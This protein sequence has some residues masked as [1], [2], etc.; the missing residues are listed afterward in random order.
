MT[1]TFNSKN[2]YKN[3]MKLKYHIIALAAMT[4]G[5]G[6]CV[7]DL[8]TVP[9]DPDVTTSET[10][11]GT[12]ESY[13]QG[14]AKIYG[15]FVTQGQDGGNSTEVDGVDG[16][17]SVFSRGVWNCQ[18]LP[19]D[20]CVVAWKDDNCNAEM[21]FMTWTSIENANIKATYYR[22]LFTVT[23]ANEYLKQTSDSK[24]DARGTDSDLRADIAVYRAETRALRAL[25][26]SY[27]LDIF[28]NLPFVTEDDPIG[29]FFP[30]QAT[31]TELFEYIESELKEIE[32]LLPAP[33]SAAYGHLD[34]GLVWGLL[35]RL[36][37]NAEVYTGTA[38][39]S[40]A[41]TWSE[42]LISSGAYGLSPV[43][44][45]LF[46]GD[47]TQNADAFQEIIHYGQSD[48]N[49][50]QNYGGTTYMVC[51]S[52]AA[53]EDVNQPSGAGTDAWGG[54]R[55]Q[56]ALVEL[57]ENNEEI[58]DDGYI[59]SPDSRCMIYTTGRTKENTDVWTFADG[60][61]VFK[62]KAMKTD[63]VY[64]E[65][66]FSDTDWIFLRLGEIYLNYAEAAVRGGGDTGKALTYVNLL[67]TRAYG[68]TDGNIASSDL[69][70]DYI[71]DERGRELHWEGFRRT[72]LIRYGKFTTGAY[73][74]PWKGG[75]DLGTGV[76]DYYTLYPIPSTD[77]AANPN[78]T[79]NDGY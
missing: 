10:V 36:Y 63:G 20:H 68:S 37:L 72:D 35:S 15:A 29:V 50:I 31:R 1:L 43:Y 28:G 22:I 40:D 64:V 46:M 12:P 60:Y 78:L 79:Q 14:L 76:G 55:A 57:F 65:G 49:Y 74:W 38:R 42:K 41:C 75:V 21:N 7:N 52:R 9:L 8:N 23:L 39:Y 26:W 5:L 13:L 19:A 70:L 73:L 69:T 62:W 44:A 24:L 45:E 71:L 17:L 27:G 6:S 56:P 67:R 66:T 53:G 30:E 34:Q 32:E 47:N 2:K 4:L 48:V 33:K 16:G 3:I 61:S 11:Y 18:E 51:A 77:M 58:G 59:A 54:I 25:A